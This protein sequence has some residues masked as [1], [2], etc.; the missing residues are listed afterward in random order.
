MATGCHWNYRTWTYCR[1]LEMGL[2]ILLLESLLLQ[3]SDRVTG[4]A[5]WNV[6]C[7][8]VLYQVEQNIF[9]NKKDEHVSE[10]KENPWQGVPHCFWCNL[11]NG[12]YICLEKPRLGAIHS[13]SDFTGNVFL[14]CDSIK[15]NDV[16]KISNVY[17]WYFDYKTLHFVHCNFSC[18]VLLHIYGSICLHFL[19]ERITFKECN[20]KSNTAESIKPL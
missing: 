16:N 1:C 14:I 8:D 5:A 9:K 12:K 19:A 20:Y 7:L 2:S 3:A 15:P 18:S 13:L 4:S 11:I 17:I 6:F 10:C